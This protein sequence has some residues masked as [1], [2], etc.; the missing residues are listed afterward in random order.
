MAALS[1]G[2]VVLFG[3]LTAFVEA[4]PLKSSQSVAATNAPVFEKDILPIF[5][6]NCLRCHDS[7]AKSSGLDLSSVK[8]VLTGSSQGPVVVPKDP[9]ASRLYDMVHDGKMPL[10]R[11]TKVS[12]AEL[13]TIRRYDLPI[14]V[15]VLNNQGYASIRTSQARYFQRLVGSDPASGMTLPDTLVVANAYGIPGMRIAGGDDVRTKVREALASRGPL[16]VDVMLPPEEPRQPSV[17]SAP[18][19]DG[20]MVSK[21]LED[22]WPFLDREEFR[23]NMIVPPIEE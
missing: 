19:R 13:E 17:V 22:L 12:A 7:K 5:Q 14:K 8:A 18:G 4:Y 11:K 9:D 6:T 23:R 20:S 2:M 10:D 21:P 15:F 16:V 1:I 3:W